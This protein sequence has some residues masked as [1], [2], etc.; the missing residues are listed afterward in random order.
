[1]MLLRKKSSKRIWKLA[2]LVLS[3]A[4]LLT[5]I[6]L[7]NVYAQEGVFEEASVVTELNGSVTSG[8]R[9]K[10][11][12]EG[13]VQEGHYEAVPDVEYE[14]AV[15]GNIED[16]YK[17]IVDAVEQQSES[18]SLAK[19]QIPAENISDIARNVLNENPDLFYVQF[20]YAE[21]QDGYITNL[22]PDYS[23]FS[24]DITGAQ[25]AYEAAIQEALS[26]IESGMSAWEKALVLH[27]WLV[28]HCGYDIKNYEKN[29]IPRESYTAYG[30]LVKGICVCSGYAS[31]YMVLAERA[32]LNCDYASSDALNHAWNMV[33]IGKYYYHLD[34]TWDDYDIDS[35]PYDVSH[36]Y[37]MLS[38][39]EISRYGYEAEH[40]AS[41]TLYDT[42][43]IRNAWGKIIFYGADMY[44]L[45]FV[46]SVQKDN[47]ISRKVESIFC[48]DMERVWSGRGTLCRDENILYYN[49]EDTIISMNLD[50]DT[51]TAEYVVT[52]AVP[53]EQKMRN[54]NIENN[55]FY[56]VDNAY[57]KHN[58][59]AY[60]CPAE[61]RNVAENIE[62]KQDFI[63]MKFGNSCK[64][65]LNKEPEDSCDWIYYS[66]DDTSVATVDKSGL[67][68]TVSCGFAMIKAETWNGIKTTSTI[69]VSSNSIDERTTISG[70]CGIGTTYIFHPE[71]GELSI[72]GNGAA[73]VPITAINHRE[74][75]SVKIAEGVTKIGASFFDSAMNIT[76]IDIPKSV[77]EIGDNAFANCIN[78]KVINLQEGL[79][80]IGYSAFSGC[81][82]ESIKL[83]DSVNSIKYGIFQSC[84]KL[85]QLDAGKLNETQIKQLVQYSTS[86][87]SIR[88]SVQNEEL[89]S[90]D[91]IVY[92][93]NKERVVSCPR[94]RDTAVVIPDGTVAIEAS[95]FQM[96]QNIPSVQL[97][98][99]LLTIGNMAF[100]GCGMKTLDFG[101]SVNEIGD[102]AF[103]NCHNLEDICLPRSV[104]RIGNE[105]FRGIY[106][107]KV[108]LGYQL[109]TIGNHAFT[110]YNLDKILVPD[111][112]ISIGNNAFWSSGSDA[113]KKT[114]QGYN[115]SYAQSYAAQ[116]GYQ[117][118]SVTKT[119]TNS[120]SF[121]KPQY[122]V[123]LDCTV[124]TNLLI[125]PENATDS[126]IEY[127]IEDNNIA[128]IDLT[129]KVTGIHMGTTK[130]TAKTNDGSNLMAETIVNVTDPVIIF[131]Y[132]Y[133]ISQNAV[134]VPYNTAAEKPENP[135]R[136]GYTFDNWYCEDAVY[137]FSQPVVHSLT[138]TAKW[139]PLR[140]IASFHAGEGTLKGTEA[141]L[142]TKEVV[143]GEKFGKLPTA[144]REGYAFLGWYAKGNES[145]KLTSGSIVNI[146]ENT[147]YY[148][149]W[150]AK[151]SCEA[152]KDFEYT[153][154]AVKP[155][156]LVKY[157]DYRLVNKKDYTLSFRKNKEVGA[158]SVQIKGKGNFKEKS[159]LSFN[160]VSKSLSSDTISYSYHR[161]MNAK[162]NNKLQKLSLKI[163]NGNVKLKEKTDYL[164]SYTKDGNVCN[165]ITDAG[166]YQIHITAE[167]AKTKHY[168]ESH[169][170]TVKVVPYGEK[171]VDDFS[172]IR[173]AGI[174]L[175]S[176]K[177]VYSGNDQMPEILSQTISSNQYT[178]SVFKNNLPCGS[179]V[180]A[181][182]YQIV[183]TGKNDYC[184]SVKKNFRVMPLALK[185]AIQSGMSVTVSD[186]NIK[187]NLKG[188]EPQITITR[189]NVVLV[190][191]I[192][193][194]CT[195]SGNKKTG[196][197]YVN[198]KGIG[199]YKG[200]LN[201]QASFQIEKKELS[202][203]TVDVVISDQQYKKQ[204]DYKAA[205]SVYD[206]GKKLSKKEYSIEYLNHSNEQV[207]L[208]TDEEYK[209]IVVVVKAAENGN[210]TGETRETFHLYTKPV[211]SLVIR[212][213]SGSVEYNG[214]RICPKVAVYDRQGNEISAEQY[215]VEYGENIKVGK[216]TIVIK[217]KSAY[218]GQKVLTFWILPKWLNRL[219]GQSIT[220][221]L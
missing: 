112:V 221:S 14:D 42:D 132:G 193:F 169:V 20:N 220:N 110:L 49:S 111:S 196:T 192:D 177:A 209:D 206:N 215:T 101:K 52:E 63:W 115:G 213:L 144:V 167:G 27:D 43:P 76:E 139:I 48:E 92:S 171:I 38:D 51:V 163:Y 145:I 204:K 175:S 28:I 212:R 13:I 113:S 88:V 138:L 71:T 214:T 107:K 211:S 99:S 83:P 77:T 2:A 158:A 36:G 208:G 56:Y 135:K 5:S 37:F 156:I 80:T 19:Y 140:S 151:L 18:I 85:Q 87:K 23:G 194:T 7:Q 174:K 4:Q 118:E 164:I 75:R 40:K 79:T 82:I 168:K 183:I 190:K 218:G 57:K 149:G 181:G 10:L 29:T 45:G 26:N 91:G 95:A 81:A 6:P 165:G 15:G 32:G 170:L 31:A 122:S 154:K 127:H 180:D 152:P 61:E 8:N 90:K 128:K 185:A 172:D 150:R 117:F 136:Y 94:G 191:G 201:K 70:N 162:K 3:V 130:L 147:D 131:D 116:Q 210:Y 96:C 58:I 173:K 157:G 105:A 84:E 47:R 109:Q 89:S 159:T 182:N 17:E 33:Q 46:Q 1:M 67:I 9:V 60:I 69:R 34:C 186:T 176:A 153:G 216:G 217:G 72:R 207:E 198:I 125:L 11:S 73:T 202:D 24:E 197:G 86:L 219:T 97:S 148:P 78:L 65:E 142:V 187:Q 200:T 188:A 50:D 54:I 189:Q 106:A 12:H 141:V 16:I 100:S 21:E 22:I 133:E 55:Y 114:I 102:N 59:S 123:P 155:D 184:G 66:S 98:D 103:S 30:A 199:N 120:I 146:V 166:V 143:F 121:A 134:A 129:G 205:V 25:D 179:I 124:S 35:H 126:N 93:K 161:T 62:T 74:I 39:T 160:I 41:S 178:V 203:S 108:V 64:M 68:Q 44:Y 104:I 137:D 53:E 195:Y 119:I